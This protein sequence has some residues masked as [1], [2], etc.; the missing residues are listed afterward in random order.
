MTEVEKI[1]RI[2]CKVAG[3]DPDRQEYCPALGSIGTATHNWKAYIDDA[4]RFIKEMEL[5]CKQEA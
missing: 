5:L 1:A 2:L 3:D 4:E